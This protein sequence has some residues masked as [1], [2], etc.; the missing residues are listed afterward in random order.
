MPDNPKAWGERLRKTREA[1]RIHQTELAGQA[2]VSVRTIY[3]AEKGVPPSS[4]VITRV[5]IALGEDPVKW[6]SAAGKALPSDDYIS[7]QRKRLAARQSSDT[8]GKSLEEVLEEVRHSLNGKPALL[9]VCYASEPT[10]IRSDEIVEAVAALI[11]DGLAL[12]MF[13]PF[14]NAGTRWYTNDCALLYENI[15]RSVIALA[16]R[17]RCAVNDKERDRIRLFQAKPSGALIVPPP[18][19]FELRPMLFKFAPSEESDSYKIGSIVERPDQPEPIWHDMP[20]EFARAWKA[21]FYPALS[22]WTASGWHPF[23]ADDSWK[24]NNDF[25]INSNEVKRRK[26]KP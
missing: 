5:A 19:S 15:S 24:M 26:L 11:K 2:D 6:V 10:G 1:K 8:R 7:A 23:G 21:Y 12:A 18:A 25:L 16:A 17:Y 22:T 3:R 9:C 20:D 4:D 14:P 13:L